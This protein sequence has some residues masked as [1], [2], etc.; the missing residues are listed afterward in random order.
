MNRRRVAIVGA[1][2]SGMQLALGLLRA[3]H[4]VTVFRTA[5]RRRLPKGR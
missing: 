4:E 2:Q 1:G 5:R 3:G